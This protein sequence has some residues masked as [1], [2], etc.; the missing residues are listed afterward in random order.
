MCS[1]ET[2]IATTL[3][4]GAPLKFGKEVLDGTAIFLLLSLFDIS[5]EFRTVD[6]DLHEGP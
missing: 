3:H 2:Q 5:L 6:L 1:H 4:V